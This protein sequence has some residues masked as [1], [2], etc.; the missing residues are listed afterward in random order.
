MGMSDLYRFFNAP[1]ALKQAGLQTIDLSGSSD[2]DYRVQAL[3]E[4][5]DWVAEKAKAP[6]WWTTVGK[7]LPNGQVCHASA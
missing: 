2:T 4:I 6:A 1:T 7:Q 5:T 3:G